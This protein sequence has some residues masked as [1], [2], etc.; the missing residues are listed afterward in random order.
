MR[1]EMPIRYWKN[2][3]EARLISPLMNEAPARVRRMLDA[4]AGA[5]GTDDE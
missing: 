2:L 4:A 3:P 1:A 5:E